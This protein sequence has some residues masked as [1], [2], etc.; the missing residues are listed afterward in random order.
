MSLIIQ[1]VMFVLS[2]ACQSVMCISDRFRFSGVSFLGIL[3]KLFASVCCRTH[4]TVCLVKEAVDGFSEQFWH[5]LLERLRR[6]RR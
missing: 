3:P 1:A 4:D 6:W 5:K 2:G